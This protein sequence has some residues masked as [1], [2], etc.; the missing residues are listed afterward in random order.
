M[1]GSLIRKHS[2]SIRGHRTSITLEDAFMDALR[3]MADQRGLALA[4]LI[5]EIDGAQATPGNLSSAL[6][7]AVLDWALNSADARARNPD[8]E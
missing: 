1:V 3:Q 6:R 4:A 8:S 2:V 7:L 5:A